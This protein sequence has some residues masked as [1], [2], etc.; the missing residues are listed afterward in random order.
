MVIAVMLHDE[1][2]RVR[3]LVV[4]GTFRVWLNG[5]GCVLV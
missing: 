4:V 3:W 2:G 1:S 5:L